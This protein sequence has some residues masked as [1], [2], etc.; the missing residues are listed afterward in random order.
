MYSQDIK[1]APKSIDQETEKHLVGKP[2]KCFNYK[3]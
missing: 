2:K 1:K 3:L